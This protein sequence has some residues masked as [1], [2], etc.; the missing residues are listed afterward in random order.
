M[1]W[2]ID[3]SYN[4]EG[5]EIYFFEMVLLEL[6]VRIFMVIRWFRFFVKKELSLEVLW[7]YF[8]YFILGK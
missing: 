1:E 3:Y 4:L 7:G 2:G 6:E 5:I 8:L